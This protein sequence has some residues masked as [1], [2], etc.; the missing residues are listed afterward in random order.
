MRLKILKLVVIAGAMVITPLATMGQ[1]RRTS[2]GPKPPSKLATIE[3]AATIETLFAS[4]SY[5]I[6]GEV[7]GV[8]QVIRS[9]AANELL[10]SILKVSKPPQKFQKL[11]KW[12]NDHTDAVMTSRVVV[13]ILPNKS[14]LPELLVAVELA[15]PEDAA[16]FESELNNLLPKLFS[17]EP[18]TSTDPNA[19]AQSQKQE[20]LAKQDYFVQRTGSLVVITPVPLLLKKLRPVG[21]RPLSEDTNFRTAHDRFSS[22]PIFLFFDVRAMNKRK[23]EQRKKY[24]EEVRQNQA[25]AAELAK[26]SPTPDREPDLDEPPD[27]LRNEVLPVPYPVPAA[28][29]MP[30]PDPMPLAFGALTNSFFNA[31][32][33]WPE[34]IG[35]SLSFENET[36]DLR[37][38]F[39]NAPAVKASV[40]PIMPLLL[41]GP[42]V[43]FE[44]PNVLPADAELV[45]I[46]SLDLPG[47]YSLIDNKRPPFV[48]TQFESSSEA[49]LATFEKKFGMKLKEDLLPLL[50][51]EVV[52]AMPIKEFVGGPSP[53]GI[54]A[55]DG[56]NTHDPPADP[57]P[58]LAL[59]LRDK[60]AMRRLLPKLIDRW[61][62]KGASSLAQTEKRDDVELVSYGNAF[63]Y[64]FIQNFLVLSTDA[65][66]IHHV[67][68]SYLNHQTL[69]SDS[70]FRNYTRWLPREVQ[71]QVFISRALIDS[72]R[73]WANEPTTLM[74]DRTRESMF[75][76]SAIAQPV[77][78][79]LTDEGFGPIHEF[80][81]PK[82]L[83][84]MA[85]AA[86]AGEGDAPPALKNEQ[87]TRGTLMWIA[88]AE[89]QFHREK[90]GDAYATLEQLV[91]EK[92]IEREAL[93]NRGYKFMLT[94]SAGDFEVTAVPM[95]YGKTGTLSYFID[96]TM[97]LRGG[98][99]GGGTATAADKPVQ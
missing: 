17:S 51:N 61:G 69:S 6:Y 40:I 75:K 30:T 49:V 13:G 10:D 79:C 70:Q 20:R 60:D 21:S 84:L 52:L 73:S 41:P 62:F 86:M 36:F 43:I 42:G 46:A 44:S 94:L 54:A 97:V 67:V 45:L 83:A 12:L 37:A 92:R 47:M 77:T 74:S 27:E 8:G 3:V 34:A 98:D 66:T 90:G 53:P 95:E 16:K 63:A 50:G 87:S 72:Y 24:E 81:V 96:E 22:D 31:P 19:S 35:V 80:R 64:A 99:H 32:P 11:V 91:E 1:Q 55:N 89:A 15:S 78:Y 33:V 28:K 9:S 26:S 93:E 7:R 39:V 68:E 5:Q 56:Q 4:D 23:E 14:D 2:N 76:L 88:S 57:S 71:G 25:A 18:D 58:V 82:S 85:I 29:T 65:A 59:S 48:P 38:L